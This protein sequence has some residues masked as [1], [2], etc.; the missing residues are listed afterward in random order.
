LLPRDEGHENRWGHPGG[1]GLA[2]LAAKIDRTKAG[3]NRASETVSDIADR[4]L[5]H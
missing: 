4:A 5:R 2:T 3:T 1:F